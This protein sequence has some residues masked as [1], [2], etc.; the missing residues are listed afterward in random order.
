MKMRRRRNVPVICAGCGRTERA[1]VEVHQT[2]GTGEPLLGRHRCET[3]L[4]LQIL[5]ARGYETNGHGDEGR[6]GDGV[7]AVPC[8]LSCCTCCS[9]SSA[10]SKASCNDRCVKANTPKSMERDMAAALSEAS[11]NGDSGTSDD[12]C[13]C[14]GRRSVTAISGDGDADRDRVLKKLSIEVKTDDCIG[15]WPDV[16]ITAVDHCCH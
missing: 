15:T 9:A 4:H 13:N 2:D 14:N 10:I 11:G 3:R 12:K 6:M 8:N 5:H 7:L 1:Y 16:D